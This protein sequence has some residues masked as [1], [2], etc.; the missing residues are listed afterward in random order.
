MLNHLC[1]Q[2]KLSHPVVGG[3]VSNVNAFFIDVSGIMRSFHSVL[4]S[5]YFSE[6]L[7]F[8][9]CCDPTALSCIKDP[10]S[11]VMFDPGEAFTSVSA[12]E[13]QRQYL[14]TPEVQS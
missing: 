8:A 13:C 2:H 12:V 1:N 4:T 14:R 10:L 5:G 9:S 11:H 6:N 7:L 3:K